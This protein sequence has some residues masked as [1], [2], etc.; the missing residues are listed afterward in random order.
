MIITSLVRRF[1]DT[2]DVPVGW[3]RRGVSYALDISSDG[4]LLGV[5][6]LEVADGKKNV[7]RLMMMP[8]EP[9]GRTSGIKASFL[10]DNGGYVLGLDPKRGIEKFN[11]MRD[12]HI[13]ILK[14]SISP[15]AKAVISYF[16]K[17]IPTDID[18]FID[19]KDALASSLAR[20]PFFRRGGMA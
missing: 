18:R 14:D 19:I 11:A 20:F 1:E 12:Y 17:G 10:C 5:I 4:R 16:N 13:R 6:S 7:R 2:Q 8:V 15:S 9:S 3:Q